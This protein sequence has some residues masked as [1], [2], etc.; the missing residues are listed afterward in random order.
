MRYILLANP[1]N[2]VVAA[3]TEH[4]QRA[5]TERYI[6]FTKALAESGA[7]LA[8]EQLQPADTATTVR[9][10]DGEVLLA[11]G[12][13]AELPEVFGG[14]WMVEAP[15]LDTVLKYAQDCPAAELGSVEVRALVDRG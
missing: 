10:R 6:A 7:L 14:F 2:A 9:V 11:D 15:D 1:Q 5:I 13:F 8:G 4:E 12:P 3:M